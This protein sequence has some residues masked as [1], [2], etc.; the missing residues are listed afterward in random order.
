[1]FIYILFIYYIYIYIVDI[2]DFFFEVGSL[3][4]A[5]CLVG[6]EPGTFHIMIRRP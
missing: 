3:S 6:F 1:M 2:Y 5:E 4:L